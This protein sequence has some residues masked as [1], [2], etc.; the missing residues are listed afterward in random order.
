MPEFIFEA[1]KHFPQCHA[2]CFLP[3]PDGRRL[4]VYFAGTKEKARDVGI[5]L[6]EFDG[7]AW[8]SPRLI[9]K[10]SEEPHW[11]PVI[12][13]V[14]EGIRLVFKTGKE[15]RDWKSHTMLSRDGGKSFGELYAYGENPAGGPV[16]SKPIRLSN[17]ALLAPNSDEEGAWL[18]RAD[19]S[20]DEGESFERW[21]K[22]PVNITDE[23][24]PDFI[25][26]KGAIQPVLW[27]SA[28]GKVHALL[29]TSGG[30][31]FRSDSLD[32]G[33]NWCTAY[34]L[35]MP[36]NNSGIDAVRAEDGKIYLICNPV[37]GNWAARTPLCVYAS[38]DNGM[39]FQHFAMVDDTPLHPDT[40]KPSELS[41]PSL[42]VHEGAL[43]AVYTWNRIAM[44]YWEKKL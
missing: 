15:I 2:N 9:A 26:G 13:P 21:G 33:K 43:Q 29:R 3:L 40:G 23:T 27:E 39:H 5:W 28:P 24:R 31:I 41:Y 42:V 25:A 17:G 32:Y 1:K 36:N 34:P 22:I 18:P 16:R 30:F 10:I 14:K 4:C 11:N 8:L 20:F 12:F 35:D 44:A 7:D 38:E 19:I 37:S 6:S